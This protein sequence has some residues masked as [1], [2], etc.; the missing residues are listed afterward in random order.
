LVLSRVVLAACRLAPR[1][2]IVCRRTQALLCHSKLSTF[3]S[4]AAPPQRSNPKLSE[5]LPIP[6]LRGVQDPI[7]VEFDSLIIIA[8]SLTAVAEHVLSQFTADATDEFN[9]AKSVDCALGN[10]VALAVCPSLPGR[11]LILSPTGP[12]TRDYDDVRRV[13]DAAKK[14][15]KRAVAAGSKRPVLAVA[16]PHAD[17]VIFRRMNEVALLGGLDELYR[18]LQAREFGVAHSVEEI[19]LLGLVDFDQVAQIQRGITVARDVGGCDPERMSPIKCAEYLQQQLSGSRVTVEVVTDLSDYP[20]ASAVGR[21]STVVERHRPVIVRLDYKPDGPPNSHVFFAGKG[22]VY[23]TGGADIKAG[24]IMAGMSRDKCGAATVAGF[25]KALADGAGK[26][27]YGTGVHF[28]AELAFVRNSVGADAYVSDEIILSHA[29]VRVKVGNT[30]AEGRMVLSDCLSHLRLQAVELVKQDP[31]ADI[32]LFSVATLT[33]HAVRAVGP[34]SIAVENGPAR[35][36]GVGRHLVDVGDEWGDC[37]EISR[38]RRED[39]DFIQ[40][41]ES[42]YDVLQANNLPSSG[43]SRGHQFPAAFLNISSGLDRHGLASDLPLAYT[44]LDI[45]GSASDKDF[46]TTGRPVTTLVTALL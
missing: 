10:E 13:F 40:P 41:K 33:G 3:S 23:D 1:N 17:G 18:P 11:R 6:A 14:G 32:Q 8:D 28:A 15:L 29:G 5:G 7:P 46:K 19:G 44:H 43:T 38:L 35:A 4:M 39:Y 22:I 12:V 27:S 45:A 26:S 16:L 42:D 31:K 9:A 20:L 24:G 37:F 21:C 34:Y 30:D 25:F 2:S 36:R